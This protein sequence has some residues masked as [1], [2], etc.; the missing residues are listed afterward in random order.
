MQSH[1]AP[2]IK[3]WQSYG[4]VQTAG[5]SD[6]NQIP[7]Q[8]RFLR[9]DSPQSFLPSVQMVMQ[10]ALSYAT[11]VM[12]QRAPLNADSSVLTCLVVGEVQDLQPVRVGDMR[13]LRF[14]VVVDLRIWRGVAVT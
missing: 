2:K 8:I 11:V 13:R 6:S 1:T 5:A 10:S 7:S 14:G 9:V 12:S 4:C 3:L